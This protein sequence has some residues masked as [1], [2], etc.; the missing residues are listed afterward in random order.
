[1]RLQLGLGN[2]RSSSSTFRR[3]GL[4]LL[5]GLSAFAAFIPVYDCPDCALPIQDLRR[6]GTFLNLDAVSA[7]ALREAVSCDFC[8]NRRRI[9]ALNKW[10]WN[11]YRTRLW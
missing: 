1:V 9:T 8:G 2:E 5:A 11:P 3:A 10:S 4:V 6:Y 7:A